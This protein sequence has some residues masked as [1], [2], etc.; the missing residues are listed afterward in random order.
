ML[1]A[2]RF[3]VLGCLAVAAL[4]YLPVAAGRERVKDKGKDKDV[5]KVTLATFTLKEDFPEGTASPG[6]FGELKLHLREV[7]ER[8]DKAAK[9]DKIGGV[10]LRLR[11]PQLGLGKVDELRGAIARVRKAGKK[12]YADV[13]SVHTKDYLIASACD[14]II[15][16]PSGELLITGLQ[17]EVTFFKGLF[18]KLGVQADFIQIGDFKGAAEPYTRTEMSP[19]FRKQFESVV[20]D[21]Y[22]Q[23]VGTIAADRKLDAGQ[24]KDL[25]DE[26]MLGA[27]RAKE[28]RLIDRVVYEDEFRE[29]LKTDLKIDEVVFQKDYGKKKIDSDFSGL[30]GFMR[31]MELMTGVETPT[32]SGKGDKIAIVYAV[33]PIMEAESSENRMFES[34]AVTSEVIIKAIRQA[35]SDSSVKGI[36]L[37]VDSP[38]G[39]ALASDL[40][41][42]D[43]VKA[44]KPVVASM[45]NTAASG[46]YYI[47][48]GADKI[49]AEPGTLTG[50]IGVVGG[51]LAIKGL[52]TKIGVTTEVIGR[53]K[54]SGVW[55]MTEPFTATERE[56][57]KRLMGDIYRQFTSK[58]AEGRKMDL[59]KLE[60]LAGGRIFSG[61]MAVANGLVDKLGTLDDA[62]VEAKLLA[63]LKADDKVDLLILPKPKNFFEQLFEGSQVEAELR[64]VPGEIMLPSEILP[65]VRAMSDWQRLF[66]RPI[67]AVLP[68]HV[69][70][71]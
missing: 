68:F 34:E 2:F 17:A 39:S 7:L 59:A 21:F 16:P 55:S 27:A 3:A 65:A 58:A 70:F 30:A 38:G 31:L 50:S 14:E 20:D 28:V 9:D 45:G 6:L 69:D 52:L 40:I 29:Q 57:W 33:G 8:L 18:D 71:N 42:R 10:V 51:K 67:N 13:E 61:R 19:E 5:K 54:N 66:K 12:V 1:R 36:V 47:S 64:I 32:K 26:G 22:D 60:S 63:G 4:T 37:R 56:T 41:W 48:M 53:G 23:L 43:V 49:L 11:N 15:M 35:E 24:V 25:I 44:K 46:G 62:V